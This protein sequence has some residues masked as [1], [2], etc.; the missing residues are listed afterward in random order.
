[1][2][3]TPGDLANCPQLNARGFF[4]EI[5][6]AV[7]GTLRYPGQTFDSSEGGFRVLRPPPLL[8]EHNDEILG[9][10]GY[11]RRDA[12]QLREAKVI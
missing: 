10:L 9:A 3:Q 5:P 6:H 4:H 11:T 1:M 12:Q 7:A 2:V 8:G